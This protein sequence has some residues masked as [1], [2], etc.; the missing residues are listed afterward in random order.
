MGCGTSSTKAAQPAAEPDVD[1]AE[2]ELEHDKVDAAIKA[3]E[4][5]SPANAK[6]EGADADNPKRRSGGGLK[7]KKSGKRKASHQG[8]I[9]R[10]A[11]QFPIIKRSFDAVH[12]T[13]E[14][15]HID[16][17][18]GPKDAIQADHLK[19]VMEHVGEHKEFSD[20][21]IKDL[22]HVANLNG[23]LTITFKEFLIAIAMGYFLKV[24]SEHE[25]FLEIQRGFKVV[26]KA[27]HDMDADGGGTVDPEEL[28]NALFSSTSDGVDP[29]ILE[30]RLK[31]LDFDGGGDISL[32]EF[33]YGMISWVGFQD[34]LAEAVP[35]S[36][37]G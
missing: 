1:K 20:D 29:A 17:G 35:G 26:E 8:M 25:E 24:E 6:A 5:A 4:A 32:P 13:F 37:S 22:F 11:L 14:E 10:L 16:G 2:A 7:K 34:E 36:A 23:E 3:E 21:E 30:K 27:F 28:K 12:T 31:E 19:D 18:K 33:M 15:Y 9:S